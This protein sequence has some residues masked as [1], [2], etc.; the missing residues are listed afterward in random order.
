MAARKCKSLYPDDHMR[1]KYILE[2]Q[3]FGI[4]PTEIIY[5]IATHFILG[6]NDEVGQ[7]CD[8]NFVMADS[9]ELA[10]NGELDVFVERVFGQKLKE[11]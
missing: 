8:A 1:L 3:V 5:E 4:A 6:F 10:K 9:A 2:N 11:G 7:G